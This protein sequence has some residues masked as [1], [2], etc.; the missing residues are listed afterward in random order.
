MSVTNQCTRV[1][2]RVHEVATLLFK[3][4]STGVY[5]SADRRSVCQKYIGPITVSTLSAVLH[6]RCYSRRIAASTP[7][8]RGCRITSYTIVRIVSISSILRSHIYTQSDFSDN[9]MSCEQSK[10][11]KTPASTSVPSLTERVST[12]WQRLFEHVYR[13]LKSSGQLNNCL[14]S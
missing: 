4:L 11:R 2:S 12:D 14:R 3:K 6:K 13:T 7:V 10:A 5:F 1:R 8:L 9:D